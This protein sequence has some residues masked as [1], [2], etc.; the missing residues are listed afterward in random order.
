MVPARAVGRPRAHHPRGGGVSPVGHGTMGGAGPV[1]DGRHA[2]GV[3]AVS[4]GAGGHV[5]SHR[6]TRPANHAMGSAATS[7]TAT[8]R[9]GRG[10][11]RTSQCT[12]A[13]RDIVPTRAPARTISPTDGMCASDATCANTWYAPSSSRTTTTEGPYPRHPGVASALRTTPTTRPLAG[14]NTGVPG[15]AAIS[16]PACHRAP[17]DRGAIHARRPVINAYRSTSGRRSLIA[18]HRAR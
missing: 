10:T 5:P 12:W 18:F 2:R 9:G 14:D 1:H 3:R 13:S 11:A 8:P 7:I 4:D 6:T 17:S 16:T 15:G